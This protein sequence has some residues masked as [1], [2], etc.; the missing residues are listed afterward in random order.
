MNIGVIFA[1]G[2]G[3][4]MHSK[5]KPKQFL[6]MYGKPIIIYTLE[7]FENSPDIDAVV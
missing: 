1:G 7:H 5:D 4:R 6:E 3:R 2:S